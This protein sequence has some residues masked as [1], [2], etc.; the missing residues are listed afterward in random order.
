MHFESRAW[1]SGYF[2]SKQG[3]WVRSVRLVC[4]ASEPSVNTKY[5]GIKSW[6][7][8]NSFSKYEVFGCWLLL[9]WNFDNLYSVSCYRTSL[10][11][12]MELI[13]ARSET[14]FRVVCIRDCDI[15]GHIQLLQGPS[16]IRADNVKRMANPWTPSYT[17]SC[18]KWCWY[19]ARRVC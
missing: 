1:L 15:L 9:V 8:L 10:W 13:G 11:A 12:D 18:S 19:H 3:S 16:I 7:L 6:Y 17:I 14:V 5:Q 2:G 4:R